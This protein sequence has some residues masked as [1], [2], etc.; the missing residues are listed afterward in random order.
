MVVLDITYTGTATAAT[1][2]DAS[3]SQSISQVN[4]TTI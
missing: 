2:Q 1:Q 3:D 4:D